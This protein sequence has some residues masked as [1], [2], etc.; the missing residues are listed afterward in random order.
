MLKL[1]NR[2]FTRVIKNNIIKYESNEYKCQYYTISENQSRHNWLLGQI[3][4][5]SENISY[6]VNVSS[7]HYCTFLKT[8]KTFYL[9][10]LVHMRM[11]NKM[12]T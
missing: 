4:T 1:Q 11:N 2:Y 12:H 8:T 7:F 3:H 6:R 5:C 9:K 10:L